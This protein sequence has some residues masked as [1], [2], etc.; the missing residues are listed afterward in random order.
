ME[1]LHTEARPLTPHPDFPGLMMKDLEA[2]VVGLP[3]PNP[4]GSSRNA[5]AARLE[6]GHLLVMVREPHNPYDP[7]AVAVY[8]AIVNVWPTDIDWKPD[9]QLGYVPKGLA[10]I[11]APLMDEGAMVFGTVTSKNEK[12]PGKYSFVKCFTG[13][14]SSLDGEEV[15]GLEPTIV[16]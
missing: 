11:Y 12:S 5:V 4:D 9:G 8:E 15:S 13:I 16:Q 14:L 6:V 2:A 7:N 10:A 1:E 3:F